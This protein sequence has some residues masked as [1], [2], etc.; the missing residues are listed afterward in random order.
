MTP[1]LTRH[2][3]RFVSGTMN[4][5]LKTVSLAGLLLLQRITVLQLIQQLLAAGIRIGLG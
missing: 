1:W 3:D 4:S 2:R 5:W